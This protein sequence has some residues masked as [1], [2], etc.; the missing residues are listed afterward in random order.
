MGDDLCVL[1]KDCHWCNVLSPEQTYKTHKEHQKKSKESP[2]LVD[3]ENVKLSGKVESG[4]VVQ[5]MTPA[6]EMT[7]TFVTPTEGSKKKCPLKPLLM[8]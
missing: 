1:K 3:P 7:T 4:Q 2:Y 8:P 6:N 5:D